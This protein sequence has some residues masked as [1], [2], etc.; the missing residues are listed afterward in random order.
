MKNKNLLTLLIFSGAIFLTYIAFAILVNFEFEDDR[1]T[2]FIIGTIIFASNF[3]LMAASYLLLKRKREKIRKSFNYYIENLVSTAGVGLISFNDSGEI[4]WISE[5]LI[6]RMDKQLIGKKLTSI[7]P[8]FAK[9]YEE[10]KPSFRFEIDK[11]IYEAKVNYENKAIILKDVTA[12]D[13][14][15][16]QYFSE[17]IVIGE[18][19]ID[20]FQHYQIILPQEE[21]FRIQSEVINMLDQLSEKFNF[22]YR[23]YVNGKYIIIADQTTIDNFIRT[24]FDFLD[25]IRKVNVVDGIQLTASIGFGTGTTEQNELVELAKEGLLQAQSRGGDQVGVITPQGKP[26]FFGSKAEIAK[27]LSRVKVKQVAEMLQ[28]RLED[29]EIKNVI[30][31]GHNFADLD[32]IGSALGLAQIAKTYGK[33]VYIQNVNWDKTTKEAMKNLFSKEEMSSMFIKPSKAK[34]LTMAKSTVVII[35]DVAE[36]NR[37]ENPDALAKANSSNI[38]V[39]DHHRVGKL[40]KKILTTN[41]YTDTTASSASEIV[42]E[43]LQFMKKT[44]KLNRS[45]AQMML[46]G[47]YLDTMQ[48]QKTTSSRT[49]QAAATLENF[50]AQVSVSIDTLKMT[51]DDEQIIRK[52][53]EHVREVK[54]GYYI[55][56]Y[57]GEVPGDIISKAADEILRTQGRKA[58][59]VVA[60][61]PGSKEFKLSARGIETNVQIIAEAVGGGGHFGAAAAVSNEPL[62]I[63]TDNIIQAIVS[64]G[65]A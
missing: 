23:Q 24:R 58:A 15:S 20:N 21:L 30:I 42:T 51:E 45:T 9:Q 27:T 57:Q 4:L 29:D 56:S 64:R 32:A 46:N 8:S 33:E 59:F 2:L 38:F 3:I 14:I 39:F 53:T 50:G 17:K 1:L 41:I 28:K 5:F 43:V 31:Y 49:F 11:I 55:A 25:I 65:D 35:T 54:P 60:K 6:K 26:E 16:K 13:I 48:F 10:G 34:R 44:I 22:T 37:T 19:E 12:E 18:L 40:D 36:A 62:T 7:S 61:I 47:I 52:I 63:F